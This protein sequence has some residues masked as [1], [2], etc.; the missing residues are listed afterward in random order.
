MCSQRSFETINFEIFVN[1]CNQM[2]SGVNLLVVISRLIIFL[3][4]IFDFVC[5]IS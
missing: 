4:H 5:S 1:S 2:Q 3:L